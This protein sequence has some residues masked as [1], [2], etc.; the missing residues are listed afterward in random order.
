MWHQEVACQITM[1][2]L[3]Y[4]RLSRYSVLTRTVKSQTEL[5]SYKNFVTLI[6][7]FTYYF[8]YFIFIKLKY[9]SFLYIFFFM[10]STRIY[11]DSDYLESDH[12]TNLS[13]S[14]KG[15][16]ER[17]IYL[18]FCVKKSKLLKVWENIFCLVALT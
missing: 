2:H 18:W 10:F 1:K 9:F 6:I 12:N 15:E 4:N 3:N 16:L 7:M 11:Y 8:I 5:F 17:V 14:V 13:S